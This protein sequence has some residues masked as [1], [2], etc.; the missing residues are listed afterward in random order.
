MYPRVSWVIEGD[1]VGCFDNI[2]HHGLM[3]AVARR[4]TDGKI[5]S[6][7]SAFLKAGY[8]ENWQFHHTHS[9]TPQ[10]G[11][12]SPLLCNIFLHQLDEFMETLGANRVQTSKEQNLRRSP[13]YRRIDNAIQRTRSKLR[14]NSNRTARK[15]L[16]D[17]LNTL[18][19]EM[20]RTPM[21]DARHQ[22]KWGYVRYADDFVI[23]VNGSENEAKDMK[24]KVEGQL[25]A[26]G[27]T[28]SVE[29]TKVTHWDQ[30][31]TFLGY[32]I[33][34]ELRAR[35]VQIRAILTIPREK[36]RQIRRELLTVASYHH[37]PE[38]DAMMS[39]NANFRGWCNYYRYATNPQITFE[40]VSHKMWWFFAHYLARKQ[41]TSLKK[42]LTLMQKSDTFKEMRKGND[43]RKT[44]RYQVGKQGY[45]LDVF[46][47]KTAKIHAVTNKESWTVDLKVVNPT[48]WIQGRSTATRLS[49]LAKSEGI[50]ERCKERPAKQ[51]HHTNRMKTK[52]TL[53]AKVRSDRDQQAKALCKE[54]HLEVHQGKWQG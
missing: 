16:L 5:L 6:L 51:V 50:C 18:E 53:L 22:T 7:V 41:K 38:L 30:P 13:E 3:K 15:E 17:Q 9:G 46:P 21:Y 2:P 40:K 29:K 14:G 48:N 12:I 34:G 52:R 43:L 27:L 39:M 24:N 26:M 33:H 36:E 28:L 37:I 32:H 4:I 42:L 25:E 45:Y 11:I 8:M 10:G 1:I 31:I 20:R 49:T 19:K 47:P 23:L 35:G 44:F 54:C